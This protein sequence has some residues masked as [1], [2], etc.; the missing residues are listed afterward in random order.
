MGLGDEFTLNMT[1]C[2]TVV[3]S[4]SWLPPHPTPAPDGAALH[5]DDERVLTSVTASSLKKQ[6]FFFFIILLKTSV[7]FV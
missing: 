2:E 3:Q 4:A 7:V 6:N 5:L 1:G